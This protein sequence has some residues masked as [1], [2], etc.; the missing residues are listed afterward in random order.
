MKE[1]KKESGMRRREVMMNMILT[2][3]NTKQKMG[4]IT[5]K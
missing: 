2:P 4:K 5:E 3:V 1:R